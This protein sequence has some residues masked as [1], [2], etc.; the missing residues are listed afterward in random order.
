MYK[1]LFFDQY[2]TWFSTVRVEGTYGSDYN[3]VK[4]I[5]HEIKANLKHWKNPVTW[6]L[7]HNNYNVTDWYLQSLGE[8]IFAENER[9]S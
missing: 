4:Q 3:R 1:I 5:E 9:K 6:I 8:L 7:Y 2:G